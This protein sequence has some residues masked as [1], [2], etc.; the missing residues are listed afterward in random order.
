[1]W[2]VELAKISYPYNM[3]KNVHDPSLLKFGLIMFFGI[4]KIYPSIALE[5]GT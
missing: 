5:L 3:G 2:I 4:V 1:M